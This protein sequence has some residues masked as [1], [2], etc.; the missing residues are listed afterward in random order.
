M[1]P[2]GLY[3]VIIL[4]TFER[5][6]SN[7][8]VGWEFQCQNFT[9]SGQNPNKISMKA[10][11]KTVEEI[12]NFKMDMTGLHIIWKL[13]D[14]FALF[15]FVHESRIC[16]LCMFFLFSPF[17]HCGW[18]IGTCRAGWKSFHWQVLTWSIG[19]RIGEDRRQSSIV[20]ERWPVLRHLK[21]VG[22]QLP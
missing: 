15:H 1:L 9:W 11:K 14:L 6:I 21:W 18:P 7:S 13:A 12:C 17:T 4:K 16:S 19:K 2:K 20:Q 10:L 5:F 3:S 8:N 22:N